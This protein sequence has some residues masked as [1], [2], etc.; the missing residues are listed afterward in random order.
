MLQIYYQRFKPY[1]WLGLSVLLLTGAVSK[2]LRGR[3]PEA[4]LNAAT[5]VVFLVMGIRDLRKGG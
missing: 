5:A 1:V 4:V 3:Y 2:Y